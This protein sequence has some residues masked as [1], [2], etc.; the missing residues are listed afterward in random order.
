LDEAASHDDGGGEEEIEVHH[1]PG[2]L[3]APAQLAEAVHP[4]LGPLDHPS[5]PQL[6]WGW[7]AL[8]GDDPRHAEVSQQR[9]AGGAVVG[10]VQ[11]DGG[12]RGEGTA[13]VHPR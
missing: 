7:H 8:A 2:L 5:L 13:L 4:G 11:V 6:A 9:A 10:S 3:G 1:R 12:I